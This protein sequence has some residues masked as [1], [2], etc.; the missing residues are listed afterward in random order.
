MHNAPNIY[1]IQVFIFFLIF[2]NTAVNDDFVSTQ[3]VVSF[4]IWNGIRIYVYPP[5]WFAPMGL[6]LLRHC[7]TL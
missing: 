2:S 1:Y 7:P 4:L 6:G 5:S 3:V